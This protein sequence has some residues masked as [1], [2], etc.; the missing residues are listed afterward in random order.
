[1]RK[2]TKLK[3]ALLAVA[4][5]GLVASGSAFAERDMEIDSRGG[6]QLGNKSAQGY[7]FDLTGRIHYDVALFNGDD[8]DRDGYPSGSHLRRAQIAVQGGVNDNWE[9]KVEFRATDFVG[10]GSISNNVNE[11]YIAYAGCKDMWFAVGQIS[12]PFSLEDWASSNNTPLMETPLPIQ[13]F[14]PGFGLGLYGEWQYDNMFTFAAA[15]YHPR[16]GIEQVAD[17]I[18][19]PDGLTRRGSDPL[20]L[21]GRVTFSPVHTAGE[22]YHFG[23]SAR[24]Q[25]VHDKH[26]VV[27]FSTRPEVRARSTPSLS[28]NITPNTVDDFQVYGL[29]AAGQWGPLV[30]QGE[31]VYADVDAVSDLDYKGYY[32][33]ASYVL[34][35]EARKYDFASGTFMGV[36]PHAKCGAWEVAGRYSF[37]DLRDSGNIG[38]GSEHDFTLGATWYANKNVR[39]MGNFVHARID[40]HGHDDRHLNIIGIRSQVNW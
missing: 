2:G 13:A 7:W 37:V 11:A 25:A 33:S 38:E 16:H 29:E 26:N 10:T 21:A 23:A 14:S 18:L 3:L 35:G 9:Y 22:V 20:A 32:V 28:T 4:G 24:T 17:A 19:T 8:H 36:T 6:I 15:L 31:F 40:R 30:V 5:L 34:T 1:M 39:F 12:V 27:N